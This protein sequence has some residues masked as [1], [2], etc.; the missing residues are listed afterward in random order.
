MFMLRMLPCAPMQ[1]HWDIF[2]RVIDNFGD[3]GVCWR[4]ARQLAAEHK[5][6]VR[7]WVD[8][9][10]SLVWLCPGVDA[11]QASQKASGVEICHWPATGFPEVV[12]ADVVIE[13]FACELPDVYLQAMSH[14]PTPPIWINLEY[15]SAEPWV[16][17]CH[18]LASP[19]SVLPLVKYFFFP[20]FS[21]KT[22]G[23]M[24]EEGLL[25]R[26]DGFQNARP[27]RKTLEVS[28]F[29]YESAPI[30]ALLEAWGLGA[31]A[32]RCRVP[33]G[34]P[35]AAITR[36]FGGHGPWQ[37]GRLRVE[38]IPFVSQ[39]EYDLLL[40]DCDLNFVRGEDSFVRAQWAGRPFVW[41]TYPQA[42]AAHFV[43]LEAFL[44]RYLEGLPETVM[45]T[46]QSFH[47]AWNQC[48]MQKTARC[49]ND[50]SALLPMLSKH[51]QSWSN[52]LADH[53]LSENLVKF[54]SDKL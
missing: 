18:A 5:L 36:H 45:Q 34:Q 35:L 27:I 8:D 19:H 7:L 39:P 52:R 41:Q 22:G 37:Y 2:C 6:A 33:P 13:A 46:V 10:A 50:F 51:G 12:P 4:L 25:D 53:R 38:P 40:W 54:C 11:S 15:L 20:G 29:C 32:V 16:E 3:I 24:C 23:L 30:G 49:W 42:D 9:L 21:H 44:Q 48:D 43:K 26:R 28:L 1:P 17:G 31:Q 14:R 47:A